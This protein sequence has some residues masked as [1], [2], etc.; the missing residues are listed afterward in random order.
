MLV[1]MRVFDENQQETVYFQTAINAQA[2]I[3]IAKDREA[4]MREKGGGFKSEAQ[5]LAGY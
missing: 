5:H 1:K 2:L 3:E 4:F